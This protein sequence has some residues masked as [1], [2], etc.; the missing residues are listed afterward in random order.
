MA[1]APED[2]LAIGELA[3]QT[4]VPA[5]MLRSWETRYGFPRPR[6]L[7]GGHRRYH[8]GDVALIRE[9][10]RQRTAG[11]SLEAAIGQAT[12]RGAEAE[13]S[14]FALRRR[15]PDLLPQVVRKSTLLALTRAMEDEYCARAERSAGFGGKVRRV[16]ELG[17]GAQLVDRELAHERHVLRAVALAH[18]RQV[19]LEGHVERPVQG[20]LDAPVAADGLSERGRGTGAGCDVVAGVEPGAVLQLG[21][22]FD[23]DDGAR[24]DEADFAGKAP[25]AV[26]PVDLPQHRDGA[27]FDAAVA[28][29]EIDV[30]FDLA[31]VGGCEG[32]LDVG[33]QAR[34][35]TF[36]GEQ[37]IGSGVADGSSDL[38]IAGDGVDGDL[39][40]FEA[41]AGGELLEQYGMAVVSLVL[42]S[43]ASCPRTR[44]LLAAKAETR[45]SAALPW[46]GRGCGARSCRRW[47]SHRQARASRRGPGP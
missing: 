29:V 4:G 38:R 43:T 19:L 21:P 15:Q 13:S 23:P 8:L 39:G 1:G 27:G 32:G 22:R 11:L 42:S 5:V 44:R 36:D 20:V 26:E 6:R 46:P 31:L 18:A 17:R 12:A 30:D 14:V 41:A 16:A 33:L 9:V 3:E 28:L 10:L 45:C 25:V 7:E 24:I 40:A 47:R 37:I 2:G 34:L 35:I